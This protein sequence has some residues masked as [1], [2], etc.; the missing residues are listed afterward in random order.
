MASTYTTRVGLE[1]QGDGENANTWG[2]V[3]NTNVIDLVDEAVA[4]YETISLAG[5]GL[6]L[7]DDDGTSN[8]ARNFGLK[9]NGALSSSITRQ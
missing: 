3:L 1:K 5:G 9:F 8:Q 2:L 4:G 7:T 6:T